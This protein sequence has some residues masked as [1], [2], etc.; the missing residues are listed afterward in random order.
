MKAQYKQHTAPHQGSLTSQ[1]LCP[2]LH[3]QTLHTLQKTASFVTLFWHITDTNLTHYQQSC[4]CNLYASFITLVTTHST[5]LTKGKESSDPNIPPSNQEQPKFFYLN[6][7]GL[8]VGYFGKMWDLGSCLPLV[9]RRLSWWMQFIKNS[10]TTYAVWHLPHNGR[11]DSS[12]GSLF[13][14][15]WCLAMPA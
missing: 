4:C 1:V 8:V 9:M 11:K 14:L 13:V 6:I 7:L 15:W 3:N 5:H 12:R 2:A 10:C